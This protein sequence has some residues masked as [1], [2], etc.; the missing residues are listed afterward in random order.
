MFLA[1]A[2]FF[3]LLSLVGFLQ[4]IRPPRILSRITPQDLGLAYEDI[5]FTTED[6]LNLAGWFI[7]H[8]NEKSA[9]TIIL[10]HGYPADKGNILPLMAFLHEH[11]NLFLFDFRGLGKS[12]GKISTAGAREVK[13]LHAAI[14]YLKSRGI[15]EVGV[16]GFSMGGA[17][18]LMA[19][20]D[21][22][23]I[24]V[25]IA[26]S[27]YA[28][29]DLMAR[30]LYR[31]PIL[32]RPLSHFTLLWA[33][34]FLGINPIQVSPM[35]SAGSLTIPILL[36][37]SRSDDVIPFSQGLMIQEA[38]KENPDAQFWFPDQLVHGQISEEHQGKIAEFFRKN[39]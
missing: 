16:W 36:I 15:D 6:G 3:L 37:H 34:G 13:D 33:A 35:K 5:T 21:A 12:E 17:V 22:P 20:P 27:P 10:L 19:A 9:K 11:Y 39:L 23:A 18:A 30:E 28:R 8:E 26:E 1:V 38:M 32:R 29:L 31:I 25:M 24:K 7:P 14:T 2:G 4:S